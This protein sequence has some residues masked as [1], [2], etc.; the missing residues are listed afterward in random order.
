[1]TVVGQT[2]TR[3]LS[4]T[5]ATSFNPR[6]QPQDR[7]IPGPV[8]IDAARP[9]CAGLGGDLR[10]GLKPSALSTTGSG[11]CRPTSCASS[12][13]AARVRCRLGTSSEIADRHVVLHQ[14][15]SHGPGAEEAFAARRL[16]SGAPVLLRDA[17][18]VDESFAPTRSTRTPHVTRSRRIRWRACC[19][20]PPSQTSWSG[21]PPT[22][23]PRGP[24]LSSKRRS[25][26]LTW[27][28]D[29]LAQAGGG[30]G[31]LHPDL[32]EEVRDRLHPRC[33]PSRGHLDAGTRAF[34]RFRLSGGA[35][36][37]GC[38][39]PV[40]NARCRAI[41][42]SPCSDPAALT[43]GRRHGP[44]LCCGWDGPRPAQ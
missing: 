29:S 17:G 28:R 12:S 33:L 22:I 13:L 5:S 14:P 41:A 37:T 10:M 35:L 30:R 25:V 4:S 36:S 2:W 8:L 38:H 34:V 7:P 3:C 39:Q 6:A 40:E 21:R 27:P 23:P 9:A 44:G 24:A 16:T 32:R 11:W 26:G 1:M 15:S 20:R 43:G 42:G 18:S 19:V 31:P